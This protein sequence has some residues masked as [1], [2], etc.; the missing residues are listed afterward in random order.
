MFC[1]Q[2]QKI[3]IFWADT[4]LHNVTPDFYENSVKSCARLERKKSRKRGARGKK[5]AKLSRETSRGGGGFHTPPVLLGLSQTRSCKYSSIVHLHVC[6]HIYIYVYS[7][8]WFFPANSEV[9]AGQQ[10][11]MLL[12]QYSVIIRIFCIL[13][14]S[15]FY[16]YWLWC[17]NVHHYENLLAIQKYLNLHCITQP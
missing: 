5:F 2:I 16:R 10:W 1:T 13:S 7:C 11:R 3:P 15:I 8:E 9:L 12:L 6:A 14:Y 4:R 17:L